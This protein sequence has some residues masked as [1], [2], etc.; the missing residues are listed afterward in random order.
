MASY[1]V[2]IVLTLNHMKNITESYAMKNS[3][4]ILLVP[5]LILTVLVLHYVQLSIINCISPAAMEN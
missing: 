3:M 1:Y 4:K 5:L 2:V